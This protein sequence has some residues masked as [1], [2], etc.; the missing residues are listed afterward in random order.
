MDI[1]DKVRMD[2]KQK[3]Y[4]EGYEAGIKAL[5]E[6]ILNDI[7]PRVMKNH[8]EKGLEL[9]FAISNKYTELINTCSFTSE[10]RR[11]E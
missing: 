5:T 10:V 3:A 1:E 7:L 9:S 11:Y 6:S 2:V 4:K 8:N